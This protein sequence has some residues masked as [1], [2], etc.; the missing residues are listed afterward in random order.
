MLPM[1]SPPSKSEILD[2]ITIKI[3]FQYQEKKKKKKDDLFL[4]GIC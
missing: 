3:N 1:R 4:E 2:D